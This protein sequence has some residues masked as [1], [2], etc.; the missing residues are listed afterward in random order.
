M[1]ARP[2]TLGELLQTPAYAGRQ[3]F[4]GKVRL[5]QDEV[6]ENLTRK[7]RAG[8]ELFP[9]VVGYDDT[10]TDLL[11]GLLGGGIVALLPDPA[12]SRAPNPAPPNPSPPPSTPSA[13]STPSPQE[14][15]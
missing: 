13:P 1:E 2:R 14:A 6:R 12:S 11:A 15:P 4:D 9:G 3:P 7:L 8:E 10:V 5:V